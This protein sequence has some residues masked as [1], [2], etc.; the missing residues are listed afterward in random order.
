[1]GSAD[2]SRGPADRQ[3]GRNLSWRQYLHL[4]SRPTARRV[5]LLAT[6]VF[7]FMHGLNNWVPEILRS[8]GMDAGRA[9]LWAALPVAITVFGAILVPRYTPA[10]YRARTLLGLF[11]LGAL[12]ACLLA[13]GSA[14]WVALGL[15]LLGVARS[16]LWPLTL[17]CLTEAEDMRREELAPAGALFFSFGELGGVLGPVLI[18]VLAQASGAFTVPLLMLAGLCLGLAAVSV[19]LDR[20]QRG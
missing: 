7:A 18:G 12:A 8:A 17:L 2:S 3:P 14:A 16:A 9:G 4:L 20:L 6:G 10:G 5:L 19:S 13:T 1:M 15:V 11:L